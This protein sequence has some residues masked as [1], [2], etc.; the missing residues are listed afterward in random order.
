MR[1]NTLFTFSYEANEDLSSHQFKF[2]KLAS[3]GKIDACDTAK[4]RALGV[5]Q[6]NPKAGEVGNVVVPP[7]Q[8]RLNT[9]AA[10]AYDAE[11]ATDASGDGIA[12]AAGDYV[13]ALSRG[14]ASARDATIVVELITYQRNS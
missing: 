1:N 10:V 5:L 7:G 9:G 12:S 4:E 13:N 6:N 11:L 2:V 8:T 3:N 14:A